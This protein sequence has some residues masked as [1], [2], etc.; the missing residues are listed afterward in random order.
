QFFRIL[1]YQE[2]GPDCL[3]FFNHDAIT[4]DM[5]E[6]C[7]ASVML[8][9]KDSL[10]ESALDYMREAPRAYFLVSHPRLEIQRIMSKLYP[11]PRPTAGIDPS[12]VVDSQAKIHPSASIGRFCIIGKCD[13]GEGTVI[14]A[15]SI[16]HDNTRIGRNV[17]IAEHC[18]IGGHGFG[19]VR[20]DNDWA[21]IP[22]I[23]GTIIEDNV[24]IF[25]F[26]N[27]D[28]G[29][30]SDTIIQR[31]SKIDHYVHVGHNSH[32]GENCIITAGT[33]TCG[34]VEVGSDCWL[35][36]GTIIRDKVVVGSGVTTG[37]GAV[38][39]RDV[40]NGLTVAGVPARPLQA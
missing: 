30:L 2:A 40:N 33:V 26:A 14:E 4:R 22:H 31:G 8:L 15:F 18:V 36:V 38:V 29:T 27:V 5:L 34:G 19:F 11:P 35:G 28:R 23:G 12:A 3:T 6:N 24:E 25:P 21:L 32:I 9:R 10:S 1:P 20:D 16:I 13:I 39:I 37:L 7:N 17:R